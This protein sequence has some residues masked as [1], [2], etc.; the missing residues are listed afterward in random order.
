MNHRWFSKFLFVLTALI[1]SMGC[2]TKCNPQWYDS[3]VYK[4][5][6]DD[7]DPYY[8]YVASGFPLATGTGLVT[9]WTKQGTFLQVVYDYSKISSTVM[10]QGMTTHTIN[11]I[12]RL[13]LLGFDGTN[14][15]VDS[16]NFD[17]TDFIPFF[18]NT[19]LAG[20]T[21]RIASTASG[22]YLTTRTAAVE[23]FNSSN[24]RIGL[25]MFATAGTCTISSGSGATEAVINGTNYVVTSNAVVTPNNKLNLHNGSTGACIAGAVPAGP[26][27]TM[28]PVNI[29]YVPDEGKLF[30][31]YYPFTGAT[32][33]A[34]IWRFDVSATAISNGELIYTDTGAE[35]ASTSA[36]PAALSS[37][38]TY[39]K[40][41]TERF[42]LVGTS[43][44]SVIKLSYDGNTL[45][46][47]GTTPLVYLSGYSR[48]VSDVMVHIK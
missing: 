21:K 8:I 31:L 17:G 16:I 3:L 37:S 47:V 34:Q 44:N 36:T 40:S 7:P 35:I 2:G 33:A 4:N 29:K 43:N 13:V 28:W 11:G 5:A 45:T 1:A 25:P 24:L 41:L 30:A 15:R 39:Y 20:G 26:A 32:T 10:P 6:C 48:S 9:K 14:G 12:K 19:G 27:T 22:G 18:T 42:I 38:I 46:K 23:F